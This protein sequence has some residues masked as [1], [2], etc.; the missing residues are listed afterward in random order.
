MALFKCS[1]LHKECGV[2]SDVPLVKTIEVGYLIRDRVNEAVLN[3]LLF[4]WL[5]HQSTL[6]CDTTGHPV[7]LTTTD[8]KVSMVT[9]FHGAD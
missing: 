5:Y 6:L 7:G 4:K 2:I 1:A 3:R 8:N 9:C